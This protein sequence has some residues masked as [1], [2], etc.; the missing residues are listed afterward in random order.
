MKNILERRN[1]QKFSKYVIPFQ[2]KFNANE[3][4]ITEEYNSTTISVKYQP[5]IN[6]KE[7]LLLCDF[8]KDY[9]Y[10]VNYNPSTVSFDVYDVKQELFDQ[11]DTETTAKKY[12][13]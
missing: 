13:L 12:N 9:T 5:A 4:I 11:F 8:F 10:Y 6:K 2:R 3:V 1:F 7:L